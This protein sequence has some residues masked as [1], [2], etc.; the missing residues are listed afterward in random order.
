[1]LRHFIVTISGILMVSSAEAA[2]LTNMSGTVM[3]NRGDGFFEINAPTTVKPGDRILVRGEGGVMIDYGE[4]CVM[5]V[6]A[7]G[8][9]VVKSKPKCETEAIGT[10]SSISGSSFKDAPVVAPV[11]AGLDREMLVVG[12]LV[13]AGGAAAVAA[14]ED[15]DGGSRPASP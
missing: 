9:T 8:S 7:Y 6:P 14:F 4:G 12:G 11:E 2:L 3:L 15:G 10:T 1:M 13:V 5:R